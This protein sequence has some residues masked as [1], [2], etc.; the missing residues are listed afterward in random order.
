MKMFIYF[1]ILDSSLDIPHLNTDHVRTQG[2][3]TAGGQALVR[4]AHIRVRAEGEV[5]GASRRDLHG[6]RHQVG[7]HT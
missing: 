5:P 4:G 3:A 6:A 1:T 2:Q 7:G